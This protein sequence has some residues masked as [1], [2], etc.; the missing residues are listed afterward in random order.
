MHHLHPYDSRATLARDAA[1]L[2]FVGTIYPAAAQAS[3]WPGSESDQPDAGG[4]HVSAQFMRMLKAYRHSGG[5]F[6][7]N[8]AAARCK[9]HGGTDAY[10]LAGWILQ[11]KV[12]SFEWLS[13]IWLPVFQFN[14]HDMSRQNG[15]DAVMS[16]LTAVCDDWEIANWMS[17]PNAWLADA[18]P[19]DRLASAATEVLDAAR[20]DRFVLAG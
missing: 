13:R 17:T 11:R 14:R 8:E 15:L 4:P 19:A 9:P 2:L 16:E 6:R 3:P 12:V 1:T 7:A 10:T 18:T 5:L 20:A